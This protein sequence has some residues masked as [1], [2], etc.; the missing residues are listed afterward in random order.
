MERETKLLHTPNLYFRDCFIGLLC[1]YSMYMKHFCS[2]STQWVMVFPL[3]NIIMVKTFINIKLMY[4]PHHHP[5][6]GRYQEKVNAI[7][8]VFKIN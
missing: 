8:E 4:T 7:T 5:L 2:I 3:L 6:M 1:V